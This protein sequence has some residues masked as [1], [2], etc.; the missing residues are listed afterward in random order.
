MVQ[1][2]SLCYIHFIYSNFLI[3]KKQTKTTETLAQ[4]LDFQS[5]LSNLNAWGGTAQGPTHLGISY[6]PDFSG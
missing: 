4:Y 1:M 6:V 5:Q 3:G 2:V